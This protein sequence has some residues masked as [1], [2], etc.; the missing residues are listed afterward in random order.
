MSRS[1]RI[2]QFVEKLNTS[3]GSLSESSRQKIANDILLP[4]KNHPLAWEAIKAL[5][6]SRKLCIQANRRAAKTYTIIRWIIAKCLLKRIRVVILTKYLQQPTATCLD[7]QK[8]DCLAEVLRAH[9]L[10]YNRDYKF[11][12]GPNGSIKS[13]LFTWGSKIDVV[14][15]SHTDSIDKTR[16]TTA[17]IFWA[18]EA[19]HQPQLVNMLTKIIGPMFA[20]TKAILILTGTPGTETDSFFRR[21]S[22]GHE[23]NWICAKYYSWDNPYYGLTSDE[24][25]ARICSHAIEELQSTYGL[26]DNDLNTLKSLS[27]EQRVNIADA[28]DQFLPD[29]IRNWLEFLNPDVQREYFGRWMTARSEYVFDFQR[30][31]LYYCKENSNVVGNLPLLK[32]MEERFAALPH[33]PLRQWYAAIGVDIGVVHPSAWVVFVYSNHFRTAY[34]LWSEKQTGLSDSQTFDRLVEITEELKRI[35]YMSPD[36]SIHTLHVQGVVADNKGSRKGVGQDWDMQFRSRV[37]SGIMIP[38]MMKTQDRV[39]AFNLDLAADRIRL[40]KGSPLD[41]EI[42][43]LKW[44]PQDPDKWK[45][46]E[47][48]KERKVVLADGRQAQ[49]GDHCIDACLYLLQD[50]DNIWAKDVDQP[51][52]YDEHKNNLHQQALK[53]DLKKFKK[54]NIYNRYR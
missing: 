41:V 10:V 49:P 3:G 11:S 14:E 20:D 26:S 46:P 54:S 47:P 5:K 2:L 36:R 13:V 12:R 48:W 31:N 6:H 8:P 35:S 17:D 9:G 19:Q 29:H 16:G 21:V 34:E 39:S 27:H 4:I 44:K 45:T 22:L 53:R 23:K 25:W 7:N 24:R 18:D 28:R 43:N 38:K 30:P 42:T 37:P 40:V 50:L 51:H 32:T 33:H 52:S 1:P 15:A